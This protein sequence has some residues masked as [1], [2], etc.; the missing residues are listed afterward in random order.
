MPC[1]VTMC[2]VVYCEYV[3]QFSREN[4]V[5]KRNHKLT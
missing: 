4:I 2:L 5:L 1:I 3:L